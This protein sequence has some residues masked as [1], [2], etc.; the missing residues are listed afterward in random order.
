MGIFFK[1]IGVVL[2]IVVGLVIAVFILAAVFGDHNSTP[3]S[4]AIFDITASTNDASCTQIGD[5]CIKAY[6]TY[7]NRG[8]GAGEKTVRAQLL[9]EDEVVAA[10]ESTLTLMPGQSQRLSWNFPEAELDDDQH[11]HHYQTKCLVGD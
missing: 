7:Y 8:N 9:D 4:A 10:R 11:Q 6:C 5:Y 2:G 3:P 1:T